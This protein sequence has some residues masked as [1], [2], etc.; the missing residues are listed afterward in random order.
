MRFRSGITFAL[1]AGLLVG[2]CSGATA[3]AASGGGPTTSPTGRVYE[4]G[5]PPARSAFT[6]QAILMN[7]QGQHENALAQS[8]L[9]IAADPTNPQHFYL[10]GEAAAG[11]GDLELADSLW[12]VAQRIYP[13]YELEIEPMREAA[14]ATAFNAG[15]EAYNAGNTDAALEAWANA[16]R[17]YPYHPN[18]AQNLAILLTQEGDYDEAIAAY[19]RGLAS[20]ER[21]PATR[22]LEATEIAE[23]DEVR[24][25]MQQSL[26][27]LL[28]F[29][30]QFAEAETLLRAQLAEDPTNVEVRANLANALTRLDRDAE[31]TTLY[32]EL[33]AS[34]NLT[35]TQL[36]TIGVSLFNANEYVKAA[37]AFGRVTAIQ[38]N[39]RD[40]WYNQANALYAAEEWE[41]LTPIAERLVQ[42]DPLNENAGLILA[43]SYRE[44]QMNDRAL[45]TLERIQ[46]LP[47]YLD[48]LQIRPTETSTTIQG[49]ATGNSAA[50]GTAVR[51]RFN[52]YGESGPLGSETVTIIAPAD[53]ANAPFEVTIAQPATSYSYEVAQ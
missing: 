32:T 51:L 38:P 42:V 7:A 9:G 39:S 27:Q 5:T 26:A 25:S 15:V 34:P 41:D 16:D 29:T 22:V 52:F 11:M 28:L 23:R 50:A 53:D 17:I 3:G 40:G 35:E 24:A 12:T 1:S 33:L 49:T 8:R 36:F 48:E 19:R 10:A 45:A 37:E 6:Q 30:D 46:A 13:A 44:R 43:R 14:W 4:P 21:T 2:G 18:A 31:A 47:I 20:L